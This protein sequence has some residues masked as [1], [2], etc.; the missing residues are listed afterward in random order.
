MRR[1]P[2]TDPREGDVLSQANGTREL[3]IDH[4]GMPSDGDETEVYYR[5]TDGLGGLLAASWAACCSGEKAERIRAAGTNTRDPA[6]VTCA[7]CK[8]VM[9][10]DNPSRTRT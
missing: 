10:K 1:D 5:V 3:H 8:R 4:V 6:L 9:A 2:R 7:A